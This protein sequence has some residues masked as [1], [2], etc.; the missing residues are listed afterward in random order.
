MTYD[1][2]RCVRLSECEFALQRENEEENVSARNGRIKEEEEEEEEEKEETH[3]FPGCRRGPRG[4]VEY[5]PLEASPKFTS[6]LL[7]LSFSRSRSRARA[8]V[9]A[10]G[11]ST[12]QNEESRRV[13]DELTY[14]AGEVGYT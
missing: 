13:D 3:I 4:L 8:R 5:A 11:K 7:F 12:V 1:V 6:L 14:N 9:S 2:G 10:S